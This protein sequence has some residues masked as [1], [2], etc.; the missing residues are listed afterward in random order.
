MPRHIKIGLIVLGIGFAVA[1]GFFVNIVGR[2]QSMM[3]NERETEENPFKPPTQPLYAP[4]DPPINVKLFFQPGAGEK[5]L[6][7][8]DDTIFKS[9]EVANRAK[10]ILQK[11]QEGPHQDGLFPSLPKDTKVQDV[12]ISAEGTAF[13]NFSNTISTNHPGGVLDELAT[14]YSIVDSLTYNVPEIKEVKILIGGIEKETLAGHC[15]LLLPLPMDLSMT[16][17]MPREETT[18]SNAAS[19]R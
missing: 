19:L 5:L 11:L 7:A 3:K 2:V 1:L 15:V 12:F 17:V 16:N 9:S 18:S 4:T 14:I 10:Q 13:V 8:A 6:I